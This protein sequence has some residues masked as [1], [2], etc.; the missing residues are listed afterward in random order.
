MFDVSSETVELREV[1]RLRGTVVKAMFLPI[2]HR[3]CILSN[4]LG[5]A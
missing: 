2:A 1:G 4:Q 3:L 5:C